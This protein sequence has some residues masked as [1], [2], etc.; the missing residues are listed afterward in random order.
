MKQQLKKITDTTMNDLLNKDIVMPSIY[1]EKFNKNAKT[2]DLNIEDSTFVKELNNILIQDFNSIEEYMKTIEKNAS[3]IKDA[4]E[5][6]QDALLH[7]DIDTLSDIY[8]QMSKLEKEISSL[9]RQ[10]FVDDLTSSHNRKWIYNKFLNKKAQFKQDGICVL[11]DII[12]FDYI[13]SE[14]GSL[15]ANNLVIFI[16]NFIKDNL[17]EEKVN[18]KIARFFD[19]QFL[20][21]IEDKKEKEISNLIFNIK[22]LLKNTTLKSKAG[23]VIRADYKYT[24]SKYNKLEESKEVFEQLFHLIQDE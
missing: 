22:E 8:S 1:F 4:V 9:N 20:I 12:D 5:D 3:L 7:K 16:N 17:K 10:L 18:F 2:L 24:I 14:Y 21:F 19:N 13:D 11:I 23:L 15:L 6:A